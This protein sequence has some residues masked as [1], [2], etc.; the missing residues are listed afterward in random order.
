MLGRSQVD[1]SKG[2]S[3][4]DVTNMMCAPQAVTVVAIRMDALEHTGTRHPPPV[5]TSK[6]Y[7]QVC[8]VRPANPSVLS[9]VT[10]PF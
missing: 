8:Q 10:C 5:E 2:A 9:C 1:N 4:H 3:R 7:M 6:T